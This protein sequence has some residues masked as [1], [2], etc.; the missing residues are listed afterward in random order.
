MTVSS[1]LAFCVIVHPEFQSWNWCSLFQIRFFKQCA[2]PT[3]CCL[4]S[5]ARALYDCA[6]FAN[7]VVANYKPHSVME[8]VVPLAQAFKELIHN[9]CLV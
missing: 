7:Q 9:Y 6:D 3:V 5:I 8:Y 1:K 4:F 2:L